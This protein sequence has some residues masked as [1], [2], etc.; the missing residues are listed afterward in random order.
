MK[1]RADFVTN[2]SSASFIIPKDNVTH[3]Q[4]VLLLNHI[5]FEYLL[6]PEKDKPY[7]NRK[8]NTFVFSGDEW[9]IFEDEENICGVTSMDNFDMER[10]L[11][12]MKLKDYTFKDHDYSA[13]DSYRE[14]REKFK[15]L[16]D[17]YTINIFKDSPCN[18]CLVGV[19]CQKEFY[20]NTACRKYLYFLK[21]ILKEAAHENKI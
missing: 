18:K 1:I 15:S 4:K 19:T 16:K 20:N 6:L 17:K 12:L 5:K 3:L 2:S 14:N 8:A 13:Y 7:Y 11:K 21:K 10:F 9:S